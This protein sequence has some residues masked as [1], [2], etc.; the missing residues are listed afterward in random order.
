MPFSVARNNLDD[1]RRTI[2]DALLNEW[3]TASDVPPFADANL[4]AEHGAPT[5]EITKYIA[6]LSDNRAALGVV[7][8]GPRQ[9]FEELGETYAL[10]GH[11]AASLGSLIF[12]RAIIA[13]Q[14]RPISRSAPR[15]SWL[16]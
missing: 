5:S 7:P 14:V 4:R 15:C 6:L 16:F 12:G 3:N 1:A 2:L 8:P 11:D 13:R 10:A 9:M